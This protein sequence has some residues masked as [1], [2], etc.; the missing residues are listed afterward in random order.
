M[1][2]VSQGG[3]WESHQYT[4]IGD[5]FFSETAEYDVTVNI[6]ASAPAP[7]TVAA[8]GALVSHNGA[9]WVFRAQNARD[10]ALGISSHFETQ[11]RKVDGVTMTAYYLPG[12]GEAAKV[13]LDVAEQALR[14][15]N[16]R[17]G[18]YPYQ[19]LAIVQGPGTQITAQ[20]H[21]GLVTI[22]SS[23]FTPATVAIYSAHELAHA[24]F[25]GAVGNDQI[26]EPWMDEGLVNSIS[27]DFLKE[28][29]PDAFANVWGAWGGTAQEFADTEPMNRD[30]FHFT[31]GPTYFRT[32]YRQGAAFF[33]S[34]REAM[35]D[36]A[37]WQALRTYYETYRNHIAEAR[38]LL[39]LLRQGGTRS[40]LL[41][42]F[43][44]FLDYPYLAYSSL[45]VDIAIPDGQVWE[46]QVSV[47][48]LVAADCPTYTLSVMLDSK[49][50]TTTTSAVTVTVDAA[51]LPDG[52]Y[53][54]R[55]VASDEG[56]N[57]S[58][59][60]RSLRVSRP[61][62]T[63]SP[64][65]TRPATATASATTTAVPTETPTASPTPAVQAAPP[66]ENEL[67]RWIVLALGFVFASAAL[68]VSLR[69]R[70]D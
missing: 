64:S 27:L 62:P 24:W 40:D 36:D 7:V 50:I 48:I 23:I 9:K 47:P 1:L 54:L 46:G 57:L 21:A 51:S 13:S 29:F 22:N 37:Y 58:D 10:F 39:R 33:Q 15:Y 28:K 69:M 63:P 8:S 20:E 18:A 45:A 2:A 67:T 55:A 30:I 34:V 12:Q 65:P 5:A 52:V 43:K 49:T 59:V 35:G 25:F 17:I 3:A 14:W 66:P 42:I 70:R 53:T 44:Q 38:D 56:V 68:V 61:T 60:Q 11:M 32:V 26:R 31:D 19:T 6:I 41:P 4:V 16:Q